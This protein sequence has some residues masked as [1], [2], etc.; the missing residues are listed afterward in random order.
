MAVLPRACVP[1]AA[2]PPTRRAPG[3]ASRQRRMP[4]TGRLY[5]RAIPRRT[6]PRERAREEE[7][8]QALDAAVAQSVLLHREQR[9]L[10]A[11]AFHE[12]ALGLVAP[13][14]CQGSPSTHTPAPPS[15]PEPLKTPA[16]GAITQLMLF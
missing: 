7:E 12:P 11:K 2:V 8:A 14:P 6:L 9:R 1:G 16:W 3:P 10:S 5:V 15:K 13:S 4:V